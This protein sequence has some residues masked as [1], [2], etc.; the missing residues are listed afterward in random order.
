MF[1]LRPEDN[2]GRLLLLANILAL[3]IALYLDYSI[4]MIIWLYWLESLAV[5]LLALFAMLTALGQDK[6]KAG[7]LAIVSIIFFAF[8]YSVFHLA[9]IITAPHFPSLAFDWAKMYEFAPAAAVLVISQALAF[10][11][12]EKRGTQKDAA[13]YVAAYVSATYGRA[14][15]IGMIMVAAAALGSYAGNENTVLFAAMLLKLLVDIRANEAKRRK[16]DGL[17]QSLEG[18]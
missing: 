9:Y 14:L 17:G 7:K 13:G 16:L 6:K 3:I 15:Q 11:W 5:G 10:Y 8:N 4:A 12:E 18:R 2:S 1:G